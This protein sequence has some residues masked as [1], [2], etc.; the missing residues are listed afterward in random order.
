LGSGGRRIKANLSYI[1]R[2]CLKK[3]QTLKKEGRKEGR[4]RGREEDN[5][6]INLDIS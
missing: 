4:E 3:I 5:V 6:T 1:V 2:V